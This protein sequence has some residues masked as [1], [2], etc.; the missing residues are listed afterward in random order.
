MALV[1]IL[2]ATIVSSFRIYLGWA[3]N[4]DESLVEILAA[5]GIEKTKENKNSFPIL[6]EQDRGKLKIHIY[7]K[8]C[9]DTKDTANGNT[10]SIDS[11]LIECT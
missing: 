3:P 7:S 8:K 9:D 11:C 1:A 5:I 10:H 6:Q 2:L 4:R